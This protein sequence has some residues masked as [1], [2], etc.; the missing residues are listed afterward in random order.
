MD[1][2]GLYEKYTVIDNETGECITDRCLVLIPQK[3]V[4]ARIAILWFASAVSKENPIFAK[5]LRDWIYGLDPIK[6]E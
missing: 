2:R 1:T 6:S 5:D 3:D 4:S